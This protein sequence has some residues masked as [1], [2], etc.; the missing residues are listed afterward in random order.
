MAHDH[1]V[2]GFDAHDHAACVAAALA[3]ADATCRDHRLKFTPIRRR[4]LEILL[5]SHAALGAYDVLDRL[6]Q[7]GR[8]AQPPVAYRA[9]SFLVE[10]GFAHRIER[11]NAYVACARPG[12]SHDPAFLICTDCGAVAEAEGAF[13]RTADTGGFR[14]AATVMEAEG[15]CPACQT[16]AT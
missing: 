2:L 14:I 16:H 12:A 9:L 5:E 1:P 4:V 15:L 3:A 13:E 8:G 11:L 7:E 10:H 6:A